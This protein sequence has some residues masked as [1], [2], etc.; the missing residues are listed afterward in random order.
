MTQ[1]NRV[2]RL[3]LLSI[4][5]QF[6]ESVEIIR[7]SKDTSMVRRKGIEGPYR[8]PSCWLTPTELPFGTRLSDIEKETR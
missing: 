3:A 1:T 5:G 6:V 8:I 2:P 4:G 7:S